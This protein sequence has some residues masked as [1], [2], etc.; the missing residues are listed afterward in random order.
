MHTQGIQVFALEEIS[1]SYKGKGNAT[2]P[3]AENWQKEWRKQNK[4]SVVASKWDSA[5][6]GQWDRGF[7]EE[8]WDARLAMATVSCGNDLLYLLT[9]VGNNFHKPRQQ[10][11]G[12]KSSPSQE[13]NSSRDISCI[14]T[15][16]S[17]YKPWLSSVSNWFAAMRLWVEVFWWHQKDWQSTKL[18]HS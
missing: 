6:G 4:T 9:P 5:A 11:I 17:A 18:N 2:E 10:C 12:A 14:L 13:K 15:V 16:L 7:W 1:L 8:K 3:E